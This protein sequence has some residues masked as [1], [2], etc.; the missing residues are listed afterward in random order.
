MAMPSA[1]AASLRPQP[2][3]RSSRSGIAI[4]VSCHRCGGSGWDP[5]AP[6]GENLPCREC[7]L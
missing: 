6:E 1:R 5:F 3:S 4:A 7:A 2:A